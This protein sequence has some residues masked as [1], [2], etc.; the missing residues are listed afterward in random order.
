M[1]RAVRAVLF[2]AII[3]ALFA[4]CTG[5]D[6]SQPAPPAA[7]QDPGT[8]VQGPWRLDA[9]VL[10]VGR[11][12]TYELGGFWDATPSLTIVVARA[13][14]NGY[15]LA[16]ATRDELVNEVAWDVPYLGEFTPAFAPLGAHD[17]AALLAF[18]IEENATWNYFRIP[19]AARPAQVEVL[20]RLVP[21]VRIEGATDRVTMLIEYAPE[22][23]FLTRYEQ[24]HGEAIA[25][26]M[27]LTATGNTSDWAWF[28]RGNEVY[29]GGLADSPGAWTPSPD[30][31]DSDPPAELVV[32]DEDDE[33][34]LWW[35][36]STGSRGVVAPPTGQPYTLDGRGEP[37]FEIRRYEATPGSWRLTGTPGDANGW[38]YLQGHAVRWVDSE[39]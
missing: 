23:G 2:A 12:W 16:A 4:G 1:V 14:A 32:V 22:V 35:V 6:A 17:D 37:N 7:A 27:R 21:G 13:D 9:P 8:D 3:T 19:L 5:D 28:E 38:A 30:G 34:L 20:G 31:I 10:S 11:S 18:P 29:T 25:W 39:G 15:L 26:S 36:G 24:R 33:V